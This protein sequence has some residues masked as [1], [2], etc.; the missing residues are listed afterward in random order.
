M[1]ERDCTALRS[2]V[3]L[4]HKFA[5]HP[6]ERA[7][8]SEGIAVIEKLVARSEHVRRYTLKKEH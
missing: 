6:P 5:L 4:L 1:T 8:L 3:D 2:L 7:I